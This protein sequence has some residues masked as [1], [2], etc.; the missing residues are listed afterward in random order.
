VSS[1]ALGSSKRLDLFGD[2][3]LARDSGGSGRNS[4]DNLLID[5]QTGECVAVDLSNAGS[6]TPYV[7]GAALDP[8][9]VFPSLER[10]I[11]N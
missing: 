7:V 1:A 3:K 5:L 9:D 2:E 11:R 8:D 4:E 6:T 10:T